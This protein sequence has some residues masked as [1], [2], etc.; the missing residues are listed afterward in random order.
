MQESG[1]ILI[2]RCLGGGWSGSLTGRMDPSE[3]LLKTT[4]KIKVH[5][6]LTQSTYLESRY[7]QDFI[8]S[9]LKNSATLVN[10]SLDE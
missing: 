10:K 5:L 3:K 1:K 7:F 2:L 6:L 9:I 4:C 8:T